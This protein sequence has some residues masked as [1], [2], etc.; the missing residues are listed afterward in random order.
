MVGGEHGKLTY[1]AEKKEIWLLCRKK[2]GVE[3]IPQN[4][5]GKKGADEPVGGGKTRS[6]IRRQITCFRQGKKRELWDKKKNERPKKKRR[7]G[8]M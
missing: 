4:E 8:A 2:G 5:F 3:Y 6:H 7:W 1:L